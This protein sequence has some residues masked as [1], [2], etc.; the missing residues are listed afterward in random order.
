MT[1]SISRDIHASGGAN[2]TATNAIDLGNN[3]GWTI[4]KLGGRNFYWIS[5]TGKWTEP[6]HWSASSG[7]VVVGC[8]PTQVDNVFLTVTLSLLHHK[9]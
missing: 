1:T 2:F 6:A 7:G 9:R 8:V 5:G 4:S 3:S